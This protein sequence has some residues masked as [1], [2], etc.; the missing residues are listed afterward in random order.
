[1]RFIAFLIL[2]WSLLW[3]IFFARIVKACKKPRSITLDLSKFILYSSSTSTSEMVKFL[4]K[5]LFVENSLKFKNNIKKIMYRYEYIFFLNKDIN[6]IY[7]I[8]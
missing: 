1:M 7:E 6:F 4:L 2:F 8:K 3:R 5:A